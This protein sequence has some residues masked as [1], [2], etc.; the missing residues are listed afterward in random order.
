M[1]WKTSRPRKGGDLLRWIE[2]GWRRPALPG[3]LL[4]LSAHDRC[5]RGEPFAVAPQLAPKTEL[6]AQVIHFQDVGFAPRG[7]LSGRFPEPPRPVVGAE[8]RDLQLP[9]IPARAPFGLVHEQLI[10][11]TDQRVLQIGQR[12]RISRAFRVRRTFPATASAALARSPARR[13]T[14][15]QPI[16]QV[17]TVAK[18]GMD[19]PGRFLAHAPSTL[20]KDNEFNREKN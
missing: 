18:D 13:L 11:P 4:K 7:G 6:H 20:K 10:E 16:L 14:A 8:N 3:S 19:H 2:F 5:P 17:E 12:R 9:L 15:R 1:D